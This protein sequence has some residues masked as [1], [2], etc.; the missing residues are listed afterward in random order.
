MQLSYDRP[1]VMVTPNQRISADNTERTWIVRQE[2][3]TGFNVVEDFH[4]DERGIHR[5]HRLSHKVS[6][7]GPPQAVGRM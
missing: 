1:C 7:V 3:G 5:K 2:I 4:S 6:A